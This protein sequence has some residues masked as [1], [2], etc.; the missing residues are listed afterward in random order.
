MLL[1]FS[2][3]KDFF[4]GQSLQS[5]A[6]VHGQ[7]MVVKLSLPPRDPALKLTIGATSWPGWSPCDVSSFRG[8]QM[9]TSPNEVHEVSQ[10]CGARG[11]SSS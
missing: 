6:S 4:T 11:G 10:I 9:H 7:V 5:S 2:T 3:A 8:D 1:G